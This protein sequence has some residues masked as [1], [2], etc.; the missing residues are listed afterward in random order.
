MELGKLRRCLTDMIRQ[1]SGLDDVTGL[2]RLILCAIVARFRSW[3]ALQSEIRIFRREVSALRRDTGGT[4]QN[5]DSERGCGTSFGLTRLRPAIASKPRQLIID[6]ATKPL[7]CHAGGRGSNP[8]RCREGFP[9]RRL[10]GGSDRR[11]IMKPPFGG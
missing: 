11:A 6:I 3:A 2:C 8:R 7:A 4:W 5:A 10:H 1:C 9:G